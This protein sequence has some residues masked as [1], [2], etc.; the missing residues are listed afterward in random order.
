MYV[1][2]HTWMLLA[3][4]F[5]AAQNSPR[6]LMIWTW[7]ELCIRNSIP[8]N[9]IPDGNKREMQLLNAARWMKFQK[10]WAREAR[11]NMWNMILFTKFKDRNNTYILKYSSLPIIKEMQIK[12]NWGGT[13]HQPEWLSS[14]VYKQD[15]PD[16]PVVRSPPASTGD[17]GLIP[18]LGRFHMPWGN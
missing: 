4:L 7:T 8:S 15:F 2:K 3:V 18:G 1:R 5:I 17:R 6:T 16:G 14:K 10:C 12:L 9:R 13:S 11:E